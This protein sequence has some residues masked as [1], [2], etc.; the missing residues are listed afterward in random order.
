[1]TRH[2]LEVHIE[3]GVGIMSRL[4]CENPQACA[5]ASSEQA[6]VGCQL[7]RLFKEVGSEMVRPGKFGTNPLLIGRVELQAL[8]VDGE[9]WVQPLDH[10]AVTHDGRPGGC[11]APTASADEE[12]P[13][14]VQTYPRVSS[15]RE[16]PEGKTIA[17]GLG[18]SREQAEG[19]Y[20]LMVHGQQRSAEVMQTW[21]L[22]AP[23]LVASS[24]WGTVVGHRSSH[25]ECAE[26][27]RLLQ[28]DEQYL[29]WRP[30]SQPAPGVIEPATRLLC[31]GCGDELFAYA[32]YLV[33]PEGV[34]ALRRLAT[35]GE[36]T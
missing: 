24:R 33:H 18:C 13:S 23:L 4:R 14:D 36:I 27:Q 3:T 34:P 2:W 26:R 9:I 1:M 19:L 5:S 11:C 31:A 35:E 7:V 12:T 6:W 22:C 32:H 25:P 28:A 29:I 17:E 30:V 16:T 20:T 21:R 8:D 10:H 15:L